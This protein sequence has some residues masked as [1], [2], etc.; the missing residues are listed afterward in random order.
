MIFSN[1]IKFK[2]KSLFDQIQTKFNLKL[3]RHKILIK[4]ALSREINKIYLH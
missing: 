4:L 1:T 2:E 3:E